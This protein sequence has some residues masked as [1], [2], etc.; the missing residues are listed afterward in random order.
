M[1]MEDDR[2]ERWKRDEEDDMIRAAT[3]KAHRDEAVWLLT[4]MEHLFP[5]FEENRTWYERWKVWYEREM[6]NR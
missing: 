1:L 5:R 4:H 6:A 3:D 2:L